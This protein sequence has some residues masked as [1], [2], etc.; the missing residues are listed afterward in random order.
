MLVDCSVY[1]LLLLPPQQ[2]NGMNETKTFCFIG[3]MAWSLKKGIFFPCNCPTRLLLVIFT[4]AK[5]FILLP[6]CLMPYATLWLSVI[7]QDVQR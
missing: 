3:R 2:S 4:P 1:S 5:T 6:C 7:Q